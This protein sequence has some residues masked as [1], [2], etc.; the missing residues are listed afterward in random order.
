[1]PRR[2]SAARQAAHQTPHPSAEPSVDPQIASHL[3]HVLPPWPTEPERVPP[4]DPN[5]PNVP[6]TSD[7][8]PVSRYLLTRTRSL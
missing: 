2:R 4:R 7:C 3:N 8:T 5:D 6:P 1:M